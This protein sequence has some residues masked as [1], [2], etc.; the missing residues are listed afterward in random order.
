MI[1]YFKSSPQRRMTKMYQH[2]NSKKKNIPNCQSHIANIKV[3]HRL[4]KDP[5][6][7]KQDPKHYQICRNSC[8]Q[9]R[10]P[11]L[12]K[13]NW[14]CWHIHHRFLLDQFLFLF[15]FDFL[16]VLSRMSFSDLICFFPVVFPFLDVLSTIGTNQT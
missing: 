10:L 8:Q 15:F 7:N 1:L 2:C 5:K 9:K 11:K 13:T 16:F 3:H 14:Q 6:G 12:K 4:L